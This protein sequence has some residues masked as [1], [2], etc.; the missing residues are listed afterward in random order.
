VRLAHVASPLVLRR[1]A[2]I[3]CVLT[4]GLLLLRTL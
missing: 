4:G 1:L 2:G 3:L